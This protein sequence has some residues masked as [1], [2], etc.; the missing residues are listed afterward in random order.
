[1]PNEFNRAKIFKPFDALKGFQEM[2]RKKELEHELNNINLEFLKII[3]NLKFNDKITILS[4]D[5]VI[6]KGTIKKINYT[7]KYI[8]INNKKIL[9]HQIKSINKLK[10]K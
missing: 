7:E 3:S 5:K 10:E 4:N 8:I 9:F 6:I 1:M 2:L